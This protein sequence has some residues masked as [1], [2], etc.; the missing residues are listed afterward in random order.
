MFIKKN[1]Y[2]AAYFED[3]RRANEIEQ[4]KKFF[5]KALEIKP[6][7]KPAILELARCF[8]E[9][10]DYEK[11]RKNLEDIL[12]DAESTKYRESL[13]LMAA[14]Y[15]EEKNY[16]KAVEYYEKTLA[17]SDYDEYKHELYYWIANCY[18][19]LKDYETAKKL[20]KNFLDNNWEPDR[21]TKAVTY[22]KDYIK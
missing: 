18:H 20:Y 1:C 7:Y 21:L 5:E 10:G 12:A 3:G 14:S 16:T 2:P 4:K 17:Y 11:C 22:A 19:Y 6:S 15:Y 8:Y 13:R 9:N